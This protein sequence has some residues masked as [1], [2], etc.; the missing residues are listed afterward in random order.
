MQ[1]IQEAITPETILNNFYCLAM[2][3]R[4]LTFGTSYN[5]FPVCYNII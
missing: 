1:I 5:N 2:I 4:Q 3:D